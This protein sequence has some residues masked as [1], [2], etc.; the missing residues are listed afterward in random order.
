MG[1]TT[2]MNHNI[3]YVGQKEADKIVKTSNNRGL[4]IQIYGSKKAYDARGLPF[5]HVAEGKL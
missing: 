3:L 2:S 1:Y 4:Y 5:L